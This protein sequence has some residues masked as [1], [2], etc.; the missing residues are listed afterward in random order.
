MN[1]AHRELVVRYY[2]S[3][4]RRDWD[5]LRD[6]LAEDVL[7]EVPQTRE[8]VRGREPYVEFNATFPGEWTIEVVRVVADAE[9]AAGQVLFWDGDRAMTGIAFFEFAGGRI[10]RVTDFWPEPYEP[11]LRASRFVERY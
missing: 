8:R 4:N 3:L 5:A 6:T 1:Q 2:Q 7:Y 11:P 10:A 9:G